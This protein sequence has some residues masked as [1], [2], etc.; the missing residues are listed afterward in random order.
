MGVYQGYGGYVEV[1]DR[2]LV[3]RKSSRVQ[4]L[5]DPDVI[6]PLSAVAGVHLRKAGWLTSGHLQVLAVGHPPAK[7]G[8]TDAFTVVFTRQQQAVFR[9]LH[10]W[11]C[12]V[13][14]HNR[15]HQVI[16]EP[17]AQS[18]PG[19]FL[20]APPQ[21][22]AGDRD[23]ITEEQQSFHGHGENQR[24]QKQVEHQVGQQR[25]LAE[26]EARRQAGDRQRVGQHPVLGSGAAPT[27]VGVGLPGGPSS[28]LGPRPA[29]P[30]RPNGPECT[31]TRP[32]LFAFVFR[33]LPH[34]FRVIHV[35]AEVAVTA[36]TAGR[37]LCEEDATP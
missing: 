34:R 1:T 29:G 32:E 22:R 20:G 35:A 2:T 3:V 36:V 25:G 10:D 4:A 12:G 15:L 31:I 19:P 28:R 37:T 14:Q 5:S 17:V 7:P 16:A 18:G 26:A 27:G 33:S 8:G 23:Q 30:G 6:I 9:S 24:R 11:L 13:A 21:H